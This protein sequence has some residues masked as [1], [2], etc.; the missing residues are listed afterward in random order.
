METIS[1]TL[2]WVKGKKNSK[3]SK[4]WSLDIK[5]VLEQNE[6]DD[7]KTVY[8]SNITEVKLIQHILYSL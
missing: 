6:V 5:N 3:L 7:Y 4:G 8:I 1:G 2:L